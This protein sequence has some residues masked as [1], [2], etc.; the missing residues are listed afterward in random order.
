MRLIFITEL[1]SYLQLISED[2]IW[3]RNCYVNLQTSFILQFHE[4]AHVI[5][6][7]KDMYWP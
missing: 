2:R 5:L 7:L 3:F 6:I 4:I 1:A